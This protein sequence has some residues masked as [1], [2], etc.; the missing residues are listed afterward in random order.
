M[1]D[2]HHGPSR[3]FHTPQTKKAGLAKYLEVLRQAGLL[4]NEPPGQ[5][6]LLFVK[7]SVSDSVE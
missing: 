7:S 1:W 5:A 4:V 6:E 3:P 2:S